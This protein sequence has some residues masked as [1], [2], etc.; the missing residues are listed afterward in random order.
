MS[1]ATLERL[2]D[3]IGIG[4]PRTGT[5]WLHE[6]LKGRVG[7]PRDHKETDFFSR[8][9]ANG[10]DWY[11]DYF[12]DCD[13]R[14]PVGEFSPTYFNSDAT[15]ARIVESIP[16]CK[17]ICTLRDPVDRAWSHWRLMVTNAWTRVPFKDAIES[18]REVR[19]SGR[20]G[21]YLKQW[22]ELFGRERVL[23]LIYDDLERDPQGF[24]D[25]TCDFIGIDRFDYRESPRGTE[26]VHALPIA[27]KY[28]QLARNARKFGT[29]LNRNR[30]HRVYKVFRN[31]AVWRWCVESGDR[32]QPPSAEVDAAVR[33]RYRPEI[34][35]LEQ[36]IGRDLSAWKTPRGRV[37][38]GIAASNVSIA[39]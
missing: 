5:T 29:W 6:V 28:R 4:P 8:N 26:R 36:L 18:L 35:L 11:R 23:V 27:P 21:T 32:F 3:F 39:V 14:L 19:E 17:I 12:R 10:L 34:E 20:Y 31:S 9:F 22:L 30:F 1:A 7:L 13:P 25:Q 15:P 37:G 16:Q 33:E 38:A 24:L 2:P